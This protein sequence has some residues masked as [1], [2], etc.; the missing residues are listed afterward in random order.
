MV[1]DDEPLVCEAVMMLLESEGHQVTRAN[2]AQ[3]ALSL[4]QPGKFDLI[5]TDFFMPWM[6]G[7]QLACAIKSRCPAQ[8]V[9]M[10]TAYSEK[11]QSRGRPASAVDLFIGKP[12]E[13][14]SLRAAITRLSPAKDSP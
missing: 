5:F 2:S 12:L 7:E 3:Q 13:L 6:T 9:V 14:E 1:V 4:F 10:L 8:P 11:L